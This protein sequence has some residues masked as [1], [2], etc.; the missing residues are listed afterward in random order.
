MIRD[1][2][3]LERSLKPV[4]QAMVDAAHDAF[5]LPLGQ[6]CGRLEEAPDRL[7]KMGDRAQTQTLVAARGRIEPLDRVLDAAES[8]VIA[9][10][11]GNET[12][13]VRRDAGADLVFLDHGGKRGGHVGAAADKGRDGGPAVAAPQL[14]QVAE[15]DEAAVAGDEAVGAALRG[16]VA[17]KELDGLAQAG[18]FDGA[19]QL[20][21]RLGVEVGAV[22][23]DRAAVDDVE[24]EEVDGWW[25]RVS[26]ELPHCDSAALSH[27]KQ[28]VA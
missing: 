15:G 3:A 4:A 18:W 7:G 8:A 9:G 6:L 21:H 25:S 13:L 26:H 17:V 24:R 20:P 12:A 11:D 22:A 5:D 16:V 2:G 27:E 19:F 14:V 1:T 10:A 28:G 23:G